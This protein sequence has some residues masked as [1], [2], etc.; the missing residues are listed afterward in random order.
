[1]KLICNQI[2]I[3]GHE[4]G[5]LRIMCGGILDGTTAAEIRTTIQRA[6][7]DNIPVVHIDAKDVREAGL[8]GINEIIHTHYTLGKYN[9][10]VVFI[11]R[12]NSV[13][14]KWV[15]VTGLDSFVRTGIV[16]SN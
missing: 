10:R 8:S 16:P 12:R 6:I 7:N 15:Q 13:V 4:A 11:Y 5:S 14:E 9:A 2:S 1:M 3:A